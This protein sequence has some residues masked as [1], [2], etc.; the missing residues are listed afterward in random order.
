MAIRNIGNDSLAGKD[1]QNDPVEQSKPATE[2][3]VDTTKAIE[4]A[5]SGISD[6]SQLEKSLR[7]R[8]TLSSK[9]VKAALTAQLGEEKRPLIGREF[10]TAVSNIARSAS[11]LIDAAARYR[12][13]TEGQ[14][15]LVKGHASQFLN[16]T[17]KYSQ[18]LEQGR[19]VLAAA[20]QSEQ[21]L[22]AL[23]S[24]IKQ[25]RTTN[26]LVQGG[27]NDL[28]Y[29]AHRSLNELTRTA[30]SFEKAA[31]MMQAGNAFALKSAIAANERAA[32][33]PPQISQQAN[34]YATAM[35][36]TVEPLAVQAKSVASALSKSDHPEAFSLKDTAHDLADKS[37][38][39]VYNVRE[40][41]GD[42]VD[43][44]VKP[45]T[46]AVGAGLKNLFN[47]IFHP[48]RNPQGKPIE[49]NK[50]VS[51]TQDLRNTIKGAQSGDTA[52]ATK[53]QQ[54]YGYNLNTAPKP[55]Q[56][57]LAANYVAGD[58]QNGQV[59][60]KK[61]PGTGSS[62]PLAAKISNK[63]PDPAQLLFGEGRALTRN[64]RPIMLRD[65]N[66]KEVAVRSMQEFEAVVAANRAKQGVPVQDGKLLPVHISLE[67]GGG[68]GKRFAPAFEEM[69]NQGVIPA[70]V[71][72][73]SVGAI[74]GALIAG[75]LDPRDADLTAKDPAVKKFFDAT[76]EG[77]GILEGRELY[78]YM[79]NKL[80]ELTGIK[81]RPVTFADLPMPLY[82]VATKF[83]DSQAP[84][85]MTKVED[86]TFVF[87]KENTPNTPVAMAVVASAA[88]PA[89]FDPIEF[90]DVATG[91]TI[92]LFDGGVV[93]QLPV[94][95]QQND[96]P[97][98]AI[99]LNEPNQNNP[100]K[101]GSPI[102]KPL[103]AGNLISNNPFGN[104]QL[105]LRMQADSAVGARDY[106]ERTA[107]PAG[108]FVLNVPT[109]NLQDFSKQDSTFEFEYN[110]KIDPELDRQSAMVTQNFL[111]SFLGKL[112]DPNA[113]GTNLNKFPANTSFTRNFT[114]N[115]TNWT[116][117]YQAGSDEVNFRS[118]SGRTHHVNLG[119]ERIETWLADDASF[120]DIAFRMR[121]VLVDHEKFV[122]T[123]GI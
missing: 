4:P 85:D 117:A 51:N 24:L 91:R 114:V 37:Y 14:L 68:K 98:I 65:A 93:D 100:N 6:S 77:P 99:Q 118:D 109:W 63:P 5:A 60:A 32:T 122:G 21:L 38:K 25:L 27:S 18:R 36:Q 96:L 76:I 95:Y 61:F 29:N 64:S 121:D 52:A 103:Q 28:L 53:L 71:T 50:L 10:Q 88:I 34:N 94:G 46:K 55:G 78:R 123:F 105:G 31:Q 84:N 102:P 12:S 54:K 67:G 80:R 66:G 33:I 30:T 86:R 119:R 1:L 82:L 39:F 48:D 81:D 19:Q 7:A 116:V 70:S 42:F 74:A 56:M 3:G 89:A 92:R 62:A 16:H 97:E 108:V 72:G 73:V 9:S 44:Y 45:L 41:V 107:P 13:H 104:A 23:D 35:K 8:N 26:G 120:G 101:V 47:S 43:E 40:T 22:G 69:Y 17:Q 79:D 75:G 115:G 15:N 90:V 113:S 11:K 57:W 112:Q 20:A 110:D 2:T 83:A 59:T 106:F 111:R 87:S 49:L 58:L